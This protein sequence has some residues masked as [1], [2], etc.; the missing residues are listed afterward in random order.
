M[1]TARPRSWFS[2]DFEV[3]D[4]DTFV[5]LLDLSWLRERGEMILHERRF[6]IG[7][8]GI[9]SGDFKLWDD[10]DTVASATKPSVLFRC[11]VVRFDGH[12]YTL[13]AR[14]PLT[15]RFVLLSGERVVGSI[16]PDHPFTRRMS[17]D[18]PDEIPLEVQVFITWLVVILWRRQ[19]NS[20]SSSASAG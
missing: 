5:A 20:A 6:E 7:R 13:R 2:W 8:E 16:A 1:L 3:F 15:R 11:F 17:I 4:G 14:S 12:E 18:L 10:G 9:L 19:H